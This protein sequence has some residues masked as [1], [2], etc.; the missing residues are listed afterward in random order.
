MVSFHRRF[1]TIYIGW[2]HKYNAHN[3]NPSGMPSVQDQYKIVSEIMEISDPTIKEEYQL[4]QLP[5]GDYLRYI[6]F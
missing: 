6:S 4:I 3:Y 1:A 5:L 2:G